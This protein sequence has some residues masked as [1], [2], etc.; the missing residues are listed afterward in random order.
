MFAR[1]RSS[2]LPP[3]GIEIDARRRGGDHDR[4]TLLEAARKRGIRRGVGN[5]AAAARAAAAA[6]ARLNLKPALWILVVHPE[7]RP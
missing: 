6:A 2:S 1:E 4:M 5:A 3:T 7:E